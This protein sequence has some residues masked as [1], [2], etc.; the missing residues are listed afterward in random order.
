MNPVWV[1]PP[2][3]P[4]CWI[5]ESANPS[6]YFRAFLRAQEYAFRRQGPCRGVAD[7][8][9]LGRLLRTVA[10]GLRHEGA[11]EIAVSVTFPPQIGPT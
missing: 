3:P 4:D 2:P 5:R 6:E 10:E 11:G 1:S 9:Q 8:T 7:R